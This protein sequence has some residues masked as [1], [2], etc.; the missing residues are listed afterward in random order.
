MTDFSG[1]TCE[2]CRVGAPP[3][4]PE[5]IEQFLTDCPDWETKTVDEEPQ[6]RR[7]F[8]F[9]DFISALDFTN[10][11]GAL[12]EQQGHHPALLT[13]WGSVTVSWWTHKIG[14]LHRND[15]I[16]AARTDELYA[17]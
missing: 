1:M 4:T 17:G 11:V 10:K 12:A 15:L 3:A 8:K 16:M 14:G 13:E 9:D 7:V 6:I 5:E 2:A